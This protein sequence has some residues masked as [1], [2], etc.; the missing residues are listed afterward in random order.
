MTT[1]VALTTFSCLVVIKPGQVMRKNGR[2][3]VWTKFEFFSA[4][5]MNIPNFKVCLIR[6]SFTRYDWLV[7]VLVQDFSIQSY[8]I[9]STSTEHGNMFALCIDKFNLSSTQLH[10]LYHVVLQIVTS[11]YSIEIT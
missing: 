6:E 5:L 10:M 1:T 9:S 3:L 11:I 8:F 4:V 7:R 2:F